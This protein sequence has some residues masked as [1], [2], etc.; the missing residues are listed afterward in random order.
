MRSLVEAELLRLRTVRSTMPILVGALGLAVLTA[1]LN[2]GAS[3]S[4]FRDDLGGVPMLILILVSSAAATVVAYAFKRGETALTYLAEPRRERVLGARMAT[5]GAAGGAF[6]A[7]ATAACCVAAMAWADHK[8]LDVGLTAADIAGR[9][10]GAAAA[11]ALIAVVGVL[12]ATAVRNPTAAGQVIV[13]AFIV[14]SF[15]P[16]HDLP[17]YLPFGAAQGLSGAPDQLAPL[18]ALALLLAYAVALYLAVPRWALGHDL[19]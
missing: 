3:P 7:L 10:A 5:Y 14:E 19:T 18:G 16:G 8:A 13:L 15:L 9:T 6:A 11:G 2:F 12:V 17:R 4:Q 1:V